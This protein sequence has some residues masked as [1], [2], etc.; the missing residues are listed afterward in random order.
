[1]PSHGNDCTVVSVTICE[2]VVFG[3][4]MTLPWNFKMKNVKCNYVSGKAV[5]A[6]FYSELM[7][8]LSVTVCEMLTG[9]M[10]TILI[11]TLMNGNSQIY[12]R[13]ASCDFVCIG[14]RNVCPICHHLRDNHVRS[15]QC[16]RFESLL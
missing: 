10:C 11:M 5:C 2:I 12:S 7:F 6:T 15:S 8:A 4:C 13:K 9:E 3:V 14:N 1:M 16:T